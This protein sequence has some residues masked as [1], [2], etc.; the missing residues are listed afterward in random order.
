MSNSCIFLP[1]AEKCRGESICVPMWLFE[2]TQQEEL[3]VSP[4]IIDELSRIKTLSL[5]PYDGV[6]WE[7]I[8]VRLELFRIFSFLF[9][10]DIMSAL[11]AVG[12]GIPEN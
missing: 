2:N 10:K 11:I 1:V 7:I 4:F 12:P 9:A 3:A 6:D 5:L 8:C